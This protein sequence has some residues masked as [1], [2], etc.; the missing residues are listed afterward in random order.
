MDRVKLGTPLYTGDSP[1]WYHLSSVKFDFW[2]N[3][4]VP[5]MHVLE[6]DLDSKADHASAAEHIWH[7]LRNCVPDTQVRVNHLNEEMFCVHAGNQMLVTV[8]NSNHRSHMRNR[9][10]EYRMLIYGDREST[11]K[12][13]SL[14]RE[15]L[16]THQIVK[17]N[18]VYMGPHGLDSTNLHIEGNHTTIQDEFYPW[19]P[20]GVNTFIKQYMEHS[21]SVLVLYGPPGTGKTSFLRH[22]LTHTRTNAMITYDDRVIQNDGF[23]VDYLTDDAHDVMIVEDADVLLAPREDG[24][25]HIMSK[26]L[27]VSDGLIRVP[28]KKMVFTTNITQLNCID[29]ALLRP[30][31]CFAAV[32]F[33]E[34]TS[35]EAAA[36]AVSANLPEQDWDSKSSWSLAQLW[37]SQDQVSGVPQEKFR[38]GF[39]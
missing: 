1:N 10:N 27:N 28:N 7:A 13:Q 17:V 21:S 12:A 29:S 24:A 5:N 23:F 19:F 32:N 34:L 22:L 36:A 26:F 8:R 9:I 39:V 18:W 31:R 3:S 15:R 37:G 25:N 16:D 14:I 6:L 11:Q 30:G 38:V 35:S 20:Q 33:R 4:S 2:N